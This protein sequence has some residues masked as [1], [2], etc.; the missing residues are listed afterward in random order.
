MTTKKD[1]FTIVHEKAG[2]GNCKA[3]LP[4]AGGAKAIEF[5]FDILWFDARGVAGAVRI[6]GA[7]PEEVILRSPGRDVF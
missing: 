6:W 3:L 4:C 1:V 7:L 2:T 5:K